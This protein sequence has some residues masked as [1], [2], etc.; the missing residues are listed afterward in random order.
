MLF[1]IFVYL[2]KLITI[3]ESDELNFGSKDENRKM[4]LAHLR[5][6]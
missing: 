5:I 4:R 1:S 2:E 6:Q 3:K